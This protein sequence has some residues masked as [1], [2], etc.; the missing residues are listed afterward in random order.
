MRFDLL[1]LENILKKSY[2][3]NKYL[4]KKNLLTQ[5]KYQEGKPKVL[6]RLII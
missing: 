3:N 6:K 4:N 5:C 2:K 1:A